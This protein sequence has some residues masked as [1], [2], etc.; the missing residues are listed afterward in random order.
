MWR[1]SGS[2]SWDE[3]EA[4]GLRELYWEFSL[5]SLRRGGVRETVRRGGVGAVLFEEEEESRGGTTG[6]LEEA[7]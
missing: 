3:K 7:C 1:D 2:E 4:E 5:V 6:G